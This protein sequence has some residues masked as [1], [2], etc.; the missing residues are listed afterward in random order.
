MFSKTIKQVLLGLVVVLLL[1][2]SFFAGR[3]LSR[4]MNVQAQGEPEI[5]DRDAAHDCSIIEVALLSNRAHIRCSNGYGAIYFFAVANTSENEVLINRMMAIGLTNLSMDRKVYLYFDAS[6]ASNPEGC[7][8]TNC[9][10]LT[11]IIGYK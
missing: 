10:K 6:F 8:T 1:L 2:G 7:L 5:G 3:M 11:G 9:R 4:T